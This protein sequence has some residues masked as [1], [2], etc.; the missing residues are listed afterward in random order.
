MNEKY[1]KLYVAEHDPGRDPIR[2]R[3]RT[4]RSPTVL[5]HP[6]V[7]NDKMR[8]EDA[9]DIVKTLIE[10]K[11]ELVAVHKEAENFTLDNQDKNAR[12]CRSTPAR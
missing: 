3:T 9:Y 7:T 5:E 11:A 1:G 2:A 12:R 10:K 4:T 8:D 6:V